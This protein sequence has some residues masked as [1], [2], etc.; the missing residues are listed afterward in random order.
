MDA[1]MKGKRIL[2]ILFALLLLLSAAAGWMLYDRGVDRSGW[3]FDSGATYYQDA[4]GDRVTL[5]QEIEGDTYYFFLE[6]AM[7]TSWQEIDGCTYYFG[8]DGRLTT[9]WQR[10]GEKLF[11]LRPD[12]IFFDGWQTVDGKTYYQLPQEGILTGWQQIDG[13]TYYFG[14]DGAMVTCPVELDGVLVTFLEDGTLA[15]GWH[16]GRCYREGLPVTGWVEHEGKLWC[17][18]ESGDPVTGWQHKDGYDYYLLSDGSAAVGPQEVDGKTYYFSPRGV[19]IWLV[20]PWNKIHED[21]T[22]EL[23]ASE[24]GY[25]VSTECIQALN[26]MLDGCRAAGYAPI[27]ISGYRSYWDQKAMYDQ[28]IAEYG[29]EYGSKVVALPDTSEHQLGLAV[30]ITSTL[31]T[32]LNASQGETKV[33]KWL[34]EHCWDYGFILRYPDGTTDIT[35]I[36]YEPW[37]YRYVGVEIAQEL[38]EL[39]IT[40][41]EYLGAA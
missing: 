30:D 3:V 7:A 20:N 19:H 24:G 25:R 1:Y 41:E 9:Q 33:Q 13:C 35:G 26:D 14:T 23:V 16:E 39:G 37:H 27:L 4:R 22:V 29:K 36:I 10:I 5:W 2:L 12:G 21:Y 6:G 11:W 28:K 15:E 8:S 17:F 32:K 38:K 18:D 34:M 40:L 31:G